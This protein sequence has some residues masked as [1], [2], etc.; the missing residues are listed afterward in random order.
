[1]FVG[2]KRNAGKVV[3]AQAERCGQPYVDNRWLGGM[4]TNYKTIRQSIRKLREL[5]TQ[6]EDGTFAKLTKKEALTRQRQL[7]KL[8]TGLGGIKDMDLSL[9]HI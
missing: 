8:E 2:T 1:M 9:I 3:K 7:D 6:S 5:E 4:L